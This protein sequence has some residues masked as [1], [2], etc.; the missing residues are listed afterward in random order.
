MEGAGYVA[1]RLVLPTSTILCTVIIGAVVCAHH[2]LIHN[3][4]LHHAVGIHA[5][6]SCPLTVRAPTINDVKAVLLYY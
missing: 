6:A 1:N 2:C 3:A 5:C 4:V